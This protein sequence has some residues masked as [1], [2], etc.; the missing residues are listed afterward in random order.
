[1][2]SHLHSP[3][4]GGNIRP[5]QNQHPSR[6]SAIQQQIQIQRE[7]INRKRKRINEQPQIQQPQPQTALLL[8]D[9]LPKRSNDQIIQEDKVINYILKLKPRTNESRSA[10]AR[11]LVSSSEAEYL[12]SPTIDFSTKLKDHFKIDQFSVSENVIGA[13]ERYIFIQGSSEQVGQAVVFISFVLRAR[14]NRFVRGEMFTLKSSNYE[15]NLLIRHEDYPSDSFLNSFSFKAI[16]DSYPLPYNQNLGIHLLHIRTDF[17][18]LF[19]FV[20]ALSLRGT[21]LPSDDF[22]INPT[23]LFGIH[24]DPNLFSLSESRGELLAKSRIQAKAFLFPS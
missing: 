24:T 14:L 23:L 13:I 8:E 10:S 15:I 19:Q 21:S 16:E 22:K 12:E 2:D 4:Q 5:N 7:N 17:N 20:V 3:I 11:I 9:P 18:T 6:S 1:M